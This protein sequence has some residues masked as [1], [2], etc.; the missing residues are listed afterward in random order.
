MQLIIKHEELKRYLISMSDEVNIKPWL[1]MGIN[2]NVNKQDNPYGAGW[3][4]DAA[5]KVFPQ[6]SSGTKSVF[7]KNPYGIDSTQ[8]N[9]YYA[10]P[11][12]QNSGAI[13]PLLVL[14]NEHDKTISREIRTVGSVFAELTFLRNF[15]FRST[16]YAD[17]SNVNS[18]VDTPLYNAWD[19]V[20]NTAYLESRRTGVNETDLTYKKFQTDNILTWK[21]K[22]SA[23]HNLTLMTGFTTYDDRYRGR[24]A[25]VRQSA[26][27]SAIPDNPRFWYITNGFE[28]PTTATNGS[29]QRRWTTASYL[30]RA[31]YNFQ[32]KYYFNASF[33]YDGTSVFP[34]NRWE[35][36]GAI[37]AAWEVTREKFMEKQKALDFLK[38][39]ASAGILGIQNTNGIDYPAY[40]TLVTGGGVPFGNITYTV[41]EP[42][43]TA[44]KDLRWEKNRAYEVG[45]ELEAVQR[46]LH[47]DFA[48]YNK[49]TTDLLS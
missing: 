32:N 20:S 33:R 9:L 16:F 2:L 14:E 10:L 43:Y 38:I 37:G 36:F 21:G 13:N 28:D 45:F 22:I 8:Q 12:V 15:S 23:D 48:Y 46:R 29:G 44:D 49:K 18:R 5:R 31:L 47:V 34:N 4:L 19:Q 11:G 40:P 26:T 35:P 7:T 39:K 24:W 3:V 17:M 25:G 42:R 30:A 1:K 6:V 27:G 41:A